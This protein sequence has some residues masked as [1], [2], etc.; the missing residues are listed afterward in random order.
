M[1]N[2]LNNNIDTNEITNNT[3]VLAS[4]F[5]NT[6]N[7]TSDTSF[8]NLI[9]NVNA[10]T[11]QAQTDINKSLKTNF[12]SI[13]KKSLENSKITTSKQ[14]KASKTDSSIKT[15][16][17]KKQTSQTQNTKNSEDT[18]SDNKINVINSKKP[19]QTNTKEDIK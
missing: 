1:T 11:Q 9:N 13:N 4:A 2:A 14:V 3:Y 15:S 7:T 19:Q 10:K 8:S 17:F 6:A 16:D 18:N 5:K 12:S